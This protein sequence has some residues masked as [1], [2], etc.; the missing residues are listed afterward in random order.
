[1]GGPHPSAIPDYVLENTEVDMVCIGE[2][3][4]AIC[5]VADRVE[6]GEPV[7]DVQNIWVKQDGEI[8]RN[9]V[10]PPVTDLDQLPMPD[11]DLFYRVGVFRHGVM[12]VTSRGCAFNCSYCIHPFLKGLYKEHGLKIRRRSVEN[13]MAE[14][15]KYCLK[16]KVRFFLFEDDDFASDDE[17][18]EEFCS[19]YE[20]EINLPF[21][22]LTNPKH[23]SEKKARMLRRAGCYQLFMGVDTGNEALRRRVLNRKHT[24]ESLRQAARCIKEAGIRLHT[25]AMFGLPDETPKEMMETVHFIQGLA[26]HSTSTYTFYPYP[27]TKLSEYAKERGLMSAETERDICE[28]KNSLHYMSVLEHPYKKMAYACINTLPI[29]CKAP[30]FLKPRLEKIIRNERLHKFTSLLYYLFIPITYP[31]FGAV[32]IKMML[33]LLYRSVIPVKEIQE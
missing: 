27:G 8:I 31:T 2:G 15:R 28:G 19:H 6:R 32:R 10:R 30:S 21:Y 18:T 11:K 33:Y 25:T 23:I 17:W 5:E 22:C 24:N 7:T 1:M 4:W 29:Y 12:V 9:P 16:Y 14:L 20:R 3:E 26:P 13:V